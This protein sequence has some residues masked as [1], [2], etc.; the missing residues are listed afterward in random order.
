MRQESSIERV[1]RNLQYR[2][3]DFPAEHTSHGRFVRLT[4]LFDSDGRSMPKPAN[5]VAN[6]ARRQVKAP[7]RAARTDRPGEPDHPARASG[8]TPGI[9]AAGANQAL[10]AGRTR[11]PYTGNPGTRSER[12][13]TNPPTNPFAPPESGNPFGARRHDPR[14]KTSTHSGPRNHDRTTTPTTVLRSP[15]IARDH[16]ADV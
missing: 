6:P 7:A 1:E 15:A 14:T 12:G 2:P 9:H 4:L 16:T 8:A 13:V 11:H 3:H 5:R 10:Q